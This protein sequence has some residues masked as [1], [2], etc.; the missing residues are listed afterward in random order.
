MGEAL[1]EAF[2]F[3]VPEE[4]V[5]INTT[6][7]KSHYAKAEVS[8][9]IHYMAGIYPHDNLTEVEKARRGPARVFALLYR[10]ENAVETIRAKLGSTDPSKAELGTI[11][12]DFGSDLMR[13]SAHASDSAESLV[14]EVQIIGLTDDQWPTPESEDDQSM[15]RIISLWY[16][17]GRRGFKNSKIE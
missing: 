2:E 3:D 15:F 10:G 14:R 8:K 6:L 13:N 17:S 5:T 1:T 9:I 12:I 16:G 4:I 11:R 7:L